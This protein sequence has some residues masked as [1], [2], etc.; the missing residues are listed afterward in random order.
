MSYASDLTDNKKICGCSCSTAGAFDSYD[1]LL[2]QK[3]ACVR[4]C[5]CTVYDISSIAITVAGTAYYAGNYVQ[6]SGGVP[7]DQAALFRVTAPGVTGPL[8]GVALL[9][10][11]SYKVKPTAPTALTSITGT[12]ASATVTV[13]WKETNTCCR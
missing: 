6:L 11:G 1:A 12:G 2:R 13:T 4:G 10:G 7:I 9:T 8:S 3:R 5:G